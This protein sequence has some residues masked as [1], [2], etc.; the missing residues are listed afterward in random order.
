[1]LD[2]ALLRAIGGDQVNDIAGLYRHFNA[3]QRWEQAALPP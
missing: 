2:F 3:L 1:M